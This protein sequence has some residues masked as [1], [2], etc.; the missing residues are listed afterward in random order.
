VALA[1]VRWQLLGGLSVWEAIS[2]FLG[3]ASGWKASI[4]VQRLQTGF[5][6]FNRIFKSWDGT[7]WEMSTA[8]ANFWAG[9]LCSN[10]YWFSALREF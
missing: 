7:S 8:A 2:L 10:V 4:P 3:Q 6:V 1:K 9:G 5:E